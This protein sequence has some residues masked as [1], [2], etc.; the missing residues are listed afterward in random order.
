MF[1]AMAEI[2]HLAEKSNI[3][4]MLPS[5]RLEV[6]AFFDVIGR[7]SVKFSSISTLLPGTTLS[8]VHLPRVAHRHRAGAKV[9]APAPTLVKKSPPTLVKKSA[10]THHRISCK[11]CNFKASSEDKLECIILTV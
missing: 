10:P 8:F 5:N 3:F 6:A 4:A 2:T 9:P 11:C 7:S 1:K